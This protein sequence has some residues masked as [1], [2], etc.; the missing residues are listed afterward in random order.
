M[1]QSGFFEV[2]DCLE[3]LSRE[4]DPLVALKDRVDF[5]RFRPRLKKLLK[6]KRGGRPPLDSVLMLKV[7]ILQTLYNLS[8]D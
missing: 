3:S 8:D 1:L 4:G 5:E 2:E 7:L 6:F